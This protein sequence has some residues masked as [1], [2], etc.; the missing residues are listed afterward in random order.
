MKLSMVGYDLIFCLHDD[1]TVH[2]HKMSGLVQPNYSL[3]IKHVMHSVED[4]P[5][6]GMLEHAYQF[7]MS[8]ILNTF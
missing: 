8:S 7:T 5:G 4:M 1:P 6:K 3:K 2:G